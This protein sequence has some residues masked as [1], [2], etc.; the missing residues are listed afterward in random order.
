[1]NKTNPPGIKSI[2]SA[3]F[4]SSALFFAPAKAT[5]STS[6]TQ[7]KH[8]PY[9]SAEIS[10]LLN[11]V[12]DPSNPDLCHGH[13]TIP[14][15]VS[16]YPNPLPMKQEI[17]SI[18]SDGETTL[19]QSGLSKLNNNVIVSQHG[20]IAKADHAQ[21]RRNGKTGKV[22]LIQMQGHVRMEQP[23]TRIA[24]RTATLNY[25]KDTQTFH[26]ALYRLYQYSQ[27]LKKKTFSWGQADYVHSDNQKNVFMRNASY[28]TCSPTNP[29]WYFN[30]ST[31]NIDHSSHEGTARNVVF[32]LHGTPSFYLPYFV[33]PTNSDRKT[34]F[35]YPGFGS[36]QIRGF[37]LSTPFYW[38]I[39]P[40]YDDTITP[41]WYTKAGL[42]ILNQFRFLLPHSRGEWDVSLMPDDKTFDQ[43]KHDNSAPSS[44]PAV[45]NL[46]DSSKLRSYTKI[47]DTTLF[48]KTLYASLLLQH[49]S[50][51]Y[52][53]SDYT[54]PVN[55]VNSLAAQQ[56]NNEASLYYD[57]Y[58]WQGVAS[59]QGYQTLHQINSPAIDQ[60]RHL[61]EIDLNGSYGSF[62]GDNSLDITTQLTRFTFHSSLDSSLDPTM[63]TGV[64]LFIKPEL[65][66]YFSLPYGYIKPSFAA[67]ILADQA[68]LAE[69]N[70]NRPNFSKSELIPITSIDLGTYLQRRYSL[71]K[72]SFI[73]TLEPRIKYT[74][75]PYRDQ[76]DFPVFDTTSLPLSYD[77][78]FNDNAFTGPDRIQNSNQ[79]ALGITSRLLRNSDDSSIL[80]GGIGIV[81]Y[82]SP[83]KV[84]LTGD[85]VTEKSKWSPLISEI[86]FSPLPGFS[87]SSTWAWNLEQ[88]Q[89]SNASTT[90]S[91]NGGNN[92]IVYFGDTFLHAAKGTPATDS[93]GDS[94]NT[95]L[96]NLGVAWPLGHHITSLNY[97]YFN[98]SKKFTQTALVG[99]QYDSCCWSA[100][101]TLTRQ[102]LSSTSTNNAPYDN[103]FS[104][105]FV[106][107]NLGGSGSS[108][109]SNS[110]ITSGIPGYTGPFTTI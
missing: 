103:S 28:T 99:L 14:P 48:S 61:P 42:Q 110:L 62:L 88:K 109:A 64:R 68:R 50:D 5:K 46:Q 77:A 96:I 89:L 101:A 82:L 17:T 98:V 11:W 1:M 60:Y 52:Y 57:G 94:N 56:L 36:N 78:L 8:A 33:F 91:F 83:P 34:G 30:A 24:S 97:L 26:H 13:Y 92:R 35:L 7:L 9:S 76:S 95:N 87:L 23:N 105:Q 18:S 104:V 25:T 69:I 90:V 67:H 86:T 100:L 41:T 65:S 93:K 31:I 40:N 6:L 15:T 80:N 20:R 10:Q 66:R 53:L 63:P 85:C 43:F 84:C 32:Y 4:F 51:A 19:L 21:I 29:V 74:Y 79:V 12:S 58:H 71:K 2:T 70:Q 39:A 27:R 72:A 45:R 81:R 102:R 49:A 107:K 108:G 38:N 16:A 44:N 59:F 75:I 55:N 73:Q 54:N 37:H 106:L 22:E 47:A 3:V